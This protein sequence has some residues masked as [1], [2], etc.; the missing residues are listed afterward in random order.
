MDKEAICNF[1]LVFW[2]KNETELWPA[3]GGFDRNM[4]EMEDTA[5]AGC[6][7]CAI[8]LANTALLRPFT[9]RLELGNNNRVF[10]VMHEDYLALS[11]LYSGPAHTPL[12]FVLKDA[13]CK[14]KPSSLYCYFL[15]NT[16][17]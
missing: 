3:M 14:I 10:V 17:S 4:K 5:A 2:T 8:F 9:E 15:F 16:Y 12:R 11:F 1:C 13:K 6:H 7:S